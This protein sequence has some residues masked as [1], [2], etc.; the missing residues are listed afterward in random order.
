MGLQAS[1]GC[2]AGSINKNRSNRV[3]ATG[4]DSDVLVGT[5]TFIRATGLKEVHKAHIYGVY[6]T[7]SHRGQRVGRDL[8]NEVLTRARRDPRVEQILLAVASDNVAAK[9]TYVAAGFTAFGME[10]RALKVGD[11]Y[12]D[13]DHMI[14][15]LG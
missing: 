13:E 15:R 14:L 4:F 5:A 8:I 10:P 9:R 2:D 7:P 1:S 12:V 6:V 11:R 3:T